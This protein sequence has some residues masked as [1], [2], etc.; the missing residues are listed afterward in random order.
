MLKHHELCI[1]DEIPFDEYAADDFG[2]CDRCRRIHE[3]VSWHLE[4]TNKMWAPTLQANYDRG[5]RQGLLVALDA[6]A[7]LDAMHCFACAELDEDLCQCACALCAETNV[8]YR[9]ITAIRRQAK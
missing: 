1:F 2:Q 5:K 9:A 4:E 7:E 8:V 6:M 3:V